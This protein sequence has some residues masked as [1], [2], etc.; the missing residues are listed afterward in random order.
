MSITSARS[1]P[2]MMPTTVDRGQ[3]LQRG[4]RLR[5]DHRVLGSVDDRAS[6]CR[7][8]RGTPRRSPRRQLP[9]EVVVRQRRRAGR[10][11]APGRARP[12]AR[13]GRRRRTPPRGPR[14]RARRGRRTRPGV[15][16]RVRSRP[17][18]EAEP[19]GPARLHPGDGV[20]DDRCARRAPRRV[21]AAASRNTSGAGLPGKPI[22]AWSLPSTRTSNSRPCRRPRS[23]ISQF[24]LAEMTAV[25][26]PACVQRLDEPAG[27][28]VGQ[29]PVFAH[30]GG[31]RGVLAVAH[32]AHRGV[33]R[34]RPRASPRGSSMPRERRKRVDTVVAADAVDVVA[35]VGVGE[36]AAAVPGR[37]CGQEPVED[38]PSTPRSGPQ[39]SA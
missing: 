16:L 18:D 10:A 31:E 17:I 8:S 20:L 26:I 22:S 3:R 28:Q 24:L 6:A 27:R 4:Q 21:G 19:A 7:R 37:V 13:R 9:G 25:R 5:G 38:R 36:R 39:R 2:L 35:V 12:V 30:R 15:G 33:A 1:R 34:A 32:R 23:T 14:S 29:H 11:G